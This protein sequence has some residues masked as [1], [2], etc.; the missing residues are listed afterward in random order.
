MCDQFWWR[1][2]CLMERHVCQRNETTGTQ[3]CTHR[4]TRPKP[5]WVQEVYTYTSSPSSSSS[6]SWVQ[7]VCKDTHKSLKWRWTVLQHVW[8][9]LYL[10]N[11]MW[12]PWVYRSHIVTVCTHRRVYESV[13][14]DFSN[15][16]AVY[17]KMTEEVSVWSS[18]VW[19]KCMLLFLLEGF[20][21][22]CNDVVCEFRLFLLYAIVSIHQTLTRHQN[23]HHL[24]NKSRPQ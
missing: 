15:V 7:T 16:S 19:V 9:D 23:D 20:C 4:C 12:T 13:C 14:V 2:Q 17:V 8:V 11:Q 22:E 18:D 21:V 1:V 10:S 24:Q 5:L 6:P 3:R